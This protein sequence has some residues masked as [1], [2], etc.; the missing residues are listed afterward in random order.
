M[1]NQLDELT[2][3]LRN[4][5]FITDLIKERLE[6]VNF[7]KNGYDDNEPVLNNNRFLHFTAHNFYRSIILDLGGLFIDRA[8]THKNNFHIIVKD[9]NNKRLL[10]PDAISDIKLWLEQSKEDITIINNIRDDQVAHLDL[11][12][13]VEI[14]MNFDNIQTLNDLFELSKKILDKINK[15][16]INAGHG[17]NHGYRRENRCLNDLKKLIKNK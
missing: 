1:K 5:F 2:Q 13:R 8:N 4:Q 11:K 6:I 14:D 9:D 7:I 10:E 17:F 12:E 16:F 3:L 15:S